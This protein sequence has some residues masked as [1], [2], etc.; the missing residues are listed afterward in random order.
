[1]S[2]KR[3]QGKVIVTIAL[4]IIIVVV[5]IIINFLKKNYK[6]GWLKTL[7][8]VNVDKTIV[9]QNKIKSLHRSGNLLKRKQRSST[10]PDRLH[11]SPAEP[12]QE[13]KS[14]SDVDVGL[15]SLHRNRDKFA[16]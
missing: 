9:Q 3:V 1:M 6:P 14:I 10:I 4:W 8:P 12:A 2:R 16:L 13:L 15:M 5:I 11:Q 7:Q